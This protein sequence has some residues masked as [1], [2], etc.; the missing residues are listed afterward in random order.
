MFSAIV[1][2]GMG[3]LFGGNEGLRNAKSLESCRCSI[4]EK[5]GNCEQSML[6]WK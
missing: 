4:E 6:M 2:D 5:E 3:I 1:K